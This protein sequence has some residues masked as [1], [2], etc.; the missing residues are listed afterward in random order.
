MNVDHIGLGSK[1][2]DIWIQTFTGAI[3]YLNNP[4]PIDINEIDIAHPLSYMCRFNGCTL[5]F[6]SVAQHSVFVSKLVSEKNALWGLLHDASEA[7]IV[8]LVSPVKRYL[9]SEYRELEKRFMK[10]ICEVY[11]LPEEMPEEVE[12][13]DKVALVTER[14]DLLLHTY[15]KWYDVDPLPETIFAWRSEVAEYQFLKR[16]WELTG[17][18]K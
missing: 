17:V 11:G 12:Y 5:W 13:F 1:K 16:L 10:V 9:S 4:K 18:E 3:V 15:P 6:Y 2:E 14:R 7:Y 8:D